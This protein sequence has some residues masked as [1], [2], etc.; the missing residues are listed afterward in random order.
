M[1]RVGV[2]NDLRTLTK[3]FGNA[4]AKNITYNKVTKTT[5]VYYENTIRKESA[6]IVGFLLDDWD[7]K[8]SVLFKS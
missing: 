3:M 5:F 2:K 1:S 4:Q 6:T 7:K 8:V